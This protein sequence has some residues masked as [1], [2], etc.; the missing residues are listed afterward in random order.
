MFRRASSSGPELALT[1][2]LVWMDSALEREAVWKG[3][4]TRTAHAAA[5]FAPGI[6]ARRR[7][8][9]VLRLKTIFYQHLSKPNSTRR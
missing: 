5:A 8:P 7:A 3:S 2:V 1:F 9:P 4:T 6:R